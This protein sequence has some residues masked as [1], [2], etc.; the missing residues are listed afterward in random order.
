[1]ETLTLHGKKFAVI[2]GLIAAMLITTTFMD[3]MIAPKHA[4]LQPQPVVSV[5]A[6]L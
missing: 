4:V 6:N 1:M 3:K 5:V 2:V